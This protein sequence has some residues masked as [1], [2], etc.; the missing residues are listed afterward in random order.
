MNGPIVFFI[1]DT[2]KIP[3]GL[4][5]K[6]RDGGKLCLLGVD[7]AEEALVATLIV[8]SLG[9]VTALCRVC[10]GDEAVFIAAESTYEYAEAKAIQHLRREHSNYA[11]LWRYDEN[12]VVHPI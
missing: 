10:P 1:V 5:S 2:T 6:L 7:K 9:G 12:L 11:P 8:E 4:V 3:Q